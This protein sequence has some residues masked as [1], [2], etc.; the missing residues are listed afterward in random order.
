MHH[1]ESYSLGYDIG[2][3]RQLERVMSQYNLLDVAVAKSSN[4]GVTDQ[5]V[6]VIDCFKRVVRVVF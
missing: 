1:W 3:A 2:L 6:G 5:F 4:G